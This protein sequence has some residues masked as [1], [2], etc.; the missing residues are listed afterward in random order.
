MTKTFTHDDVT[1]FLYGEMNEAERADF[2]I[3]LEFDMDLREE[4]LVQQ[5]LK[6]SLEK[7]I[8]EPSRGVT[9]RILEYSRNWEPLAAEA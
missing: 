2:M 1:K 7:A 5:N 3:T 4:Y 9:E 8:C 6:S